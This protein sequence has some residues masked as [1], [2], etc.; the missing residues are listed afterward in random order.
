M[1]ENAVAE[2]LADEN[3]REEMG[4]N[5]LQVI[6]ENRGAMARTVD[7]LLEN[8]KGRGIYIAPEMSP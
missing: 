8:L 3:R 1:L 2:L 6:S 7:L 5:A 4:R